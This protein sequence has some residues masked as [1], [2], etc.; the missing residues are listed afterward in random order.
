MLCTFSEIWLTCWKDY[1][2]H[3]ALFST[4]IFLLSSRRLKHDWTLSKHRHWMC[5]VIPTVSCLSLIL[6]GVLDKSG[7]KL[8]GIFRLCCHQV[9]EDAPGFETSQSFVQIWGHAGEKSY[10]NFYFCDFSDVDF[11]FYIYF[12]SLSGL[13]LWCL[14]FMI[15]LDCSLFLPKNL[16]SPFVHFRFNTN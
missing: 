4:F 1:V 12:R 10:F 14:P 2:C 6:P 15:G 5:F 7:G 8:T 11:C 16:V 9:P 3:N 13:I